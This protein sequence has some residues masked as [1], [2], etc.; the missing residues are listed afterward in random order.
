M[1][2]RQLEQVLGR[3]LSDAIVPGD[4]SG[5]APVPCQFSIVNLV[6]HPTVR[7]FVVTGHDI[8]ELRKARNEL[9]HLAGHDLLT[10]LPNRNRLVDALRRRLPNLD[11]RSQ[12]WLRLSTSTASS[13][14]MTCTAMTPATSYLSVWLADSKT[15]F[16]TTI[17]PILTR[18]RSDPHCAG[19]GL[20]IV[21][22]AGAHLGE[23]RGH[24]FVSKAAM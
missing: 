24:C 13:Q 22:R 7:A 21:H 5:R 17:T 3:P 10:R 12:T 16:V 18:W 4:H 15:R 9:E 8:S 11:R 14:Y 6:D 23:R 20:R 2:S 1:T 19:P